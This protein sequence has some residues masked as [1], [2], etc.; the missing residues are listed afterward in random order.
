MTNY[1]HW[2]IRARL[3][4]R[5]LLLLM[6]L[7]EEGNIHRAAQVL[8]MTQPAASKLLKD[9]EEMLGVELF[10]RLPRGMRPT[11]Y[12]ETM[13]RHARMALANLS[14][15]HDE[16]EALKAG[17][18]GQ[19]SIGAITAPGMAL[20]PA[21]V[22]QVKQEHPNLAVSV[23]IES[24]DVLLERLAQGKLDLM[25][26]RLFERHDKSDLR[27]EAL[28]EEPVCAVVRPGHPLLGVARLGLRDL[29]NVGW[30]VP[31]TGSVLRHRFELMFQEEGLETPVN[32][33][34]SQALLFVTKML[35]QSDMVAVVAADVGRYYAEHGLVAV[36]PITLPCKMDAFG[37]ITRT[38]RL[39][40]PAAKVMLRAVRN[41]AVSVYG[42]R[43]GE[44]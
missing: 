39:L 19:V 27:Y 29:V 9:L 28:A 5:Q 25:I 34:D 7:E 2:F 24:S 23:A 30:I 35:Q 31:P 12:G 16:I 13:I 37:L 15:A 1:T 42:V 38:D 26:G 44:G 36:L 33:V 17:R 11:W 21:A 4:T 6:A 8:N 18:F 14:Q 41:A 10:Q 32:L 40:S 43:L 3:K 20:L 22:A